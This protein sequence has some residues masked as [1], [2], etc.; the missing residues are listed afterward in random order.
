MIDKEKLTAFINDQL[1]ETA[2][3]LTDLKITPQNEITVEID[4]SGAVDIDECI[5]LTRAIESAFDRDEE[6]YELEV[7]S[8]GLTSPLKD[9]RQYAKHIG[10]DV[11]VLTADGRKLHGML[12]A[13][14]PEGFT[15]LT[16]RKVKPEGAKRP[17]LE[18]TEERFGY[19]DVKYTKYDLKF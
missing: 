9:P 7:G 6:D 11:E 10:H 19:G 4:G 2:Y 15:L 18:Q 8:A 1:K 13:A 3:F 17:V 12:R 5:S 16:E 14:D